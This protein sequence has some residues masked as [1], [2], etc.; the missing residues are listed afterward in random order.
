[1]RI[2]VIEDEASLQEALAYNFTT[3]GYEVV[4]AVR[5]DE[6]LRI[7]QAGGVDLVLLDLML[8]DRSGTDVCRALK[9]NPRTQR[10]PVVILTAKGDEIDRVVGFELGAD[11]YVTKPFSVRELLL[12]VQ[13]ILRRSREV[14]PSRSTEIVFGALR[15]DPEAHRVFVSGVEVELTPIELKLLIT[16]HARKN[17]VQSRETLLEQ[18]WGY[19]AEMETRTVDTHVKR[20]REKLGRAG[21]YIETVRGAGYRFAD[22][23]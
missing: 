5:G 16:L 3:A 4:S 22:A 12:R 17:R 19:N 13:A 21:D 9:T 15:V 11:D 14:E 7:A 1:M 18:V 20:L 6:G 8:P 10:I 2:L 23:P